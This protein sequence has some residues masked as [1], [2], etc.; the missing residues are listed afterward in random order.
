MACDAEGVFPAPT[1]RLDVFVIDVA[2]G[3]HA[4][5]L[6]HALRAA[7]VR[8]DRAFDDRSMKA[9]MKQADRSGARWALIVGE[10]EVADGTAV[11]RDLR[12]SEQQAVARGDV[13]DH[14]RKLI[15]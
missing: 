2:G 8:A 11:V 1:A 10:Q 6:T 15:S 3:E 9:Q 5:E 13:V 12:G 14:V 7:G 4:L